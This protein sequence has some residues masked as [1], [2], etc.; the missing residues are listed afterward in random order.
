[1]PCG[2]VSNT[3]SDKGA[4]CGMKP[5]CNL[6]VMKYFEDLFVKLQVKAFSAA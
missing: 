6:F 5:I 1:M 4:N 3:L 2:K